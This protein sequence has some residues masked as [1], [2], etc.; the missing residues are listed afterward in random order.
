MTPGRRGRSCTR[1]RAAARGGVVEHGHPAGLAL[2][3]IP[4]RDL[5]RLR[6]E[7]HH[8]V[9]LRERDVQPLTIVAYDDVEGLGADVDLSHERGQPGGLTQLSELPCLAQ[10]QPDPVAVA[11]EAGGLS[12][13]GELEMLGARPRRHQQGA[14]VGVGDVLAQGVARQHHHAR[15]GGV[16]DRLGDRLGLWSRLL[17]H[18]IDGVWGLRHHAGGRGGLAGGDQEQV[19]YRQ[20]TGH[21]VLPAGRDALASQLALRVF[22]PSPPIGAV[23]SSPN[24]SAATPA[25]W[26]IVR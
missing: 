12:R 19:V 1:R 9:L 2:D 26:S 14:V 25:A 20:V 6:V 24:P 18:R 4:G 11:H 3:R 13:E 22:Y 15:A 23:P 5:Q 7:P 17:V 8:L 10:R 21:V 16:A